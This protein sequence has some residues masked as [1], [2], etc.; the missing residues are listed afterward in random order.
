MSSAAWK[1]TCCAPSPQHWTA[2]RTPSCG[3]PGE[4]AHSSPPPA[5]NFVMPRTNVLVHRGWPV[6]LQSIGPRPWMRAWSENRWVATRW[7]TRSGPRRRG[8]QSTSKSGSAS[9]SRLHRRGVTRRVPE[10]VRAAKREDEEGNHSD[11]STPTPPV[12]CTTSDTEA[13]A[14][15][16]EAEPWSQW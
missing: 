8:G 3:F 16:R 12:A 4:L 5:L 2:A 6:R 15:S 9:R 10:V 7:H 14:S 13:R 1:F 11:T